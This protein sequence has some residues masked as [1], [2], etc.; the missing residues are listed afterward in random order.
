[1]QTEN[2]K[3][4]IGF[5]PYSVAGMAYIPYFLKSIEE[6]TYKDFTILAV[7]GNED[8]TD[9]NIKALAGYPQIKIISKG[10]NH[11]FGKSFNLMIN[12]SKKNGAEYFLVLNMDTILDKD[13]IK[14]MLTALKSNS[15]LGSVSPKIYKWNFA[16]EKLSEKTKIID[17]FGIILK[18]GL[19]FFDLGQ[20]QIDQGQFD[21][22]KI[23]GPSGAAAMY[24]MDALEKVKIDNQYFDEQMFMYK[25]DCDLAYRLFLAGYSSM[26]VTNAKIYHDRTAAGAGDGIFSVLSNRKNKSKQIKKWSLFHQLIII[27]KYWNLQNTL[28]KINIVWYVLQLFIFSLIF[29]QYLLFGFI[30][31]LKTKVKR[32]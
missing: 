32:Y 8:G 10:I 26:L 30:K 21:N 14:N 18:S 15:K 1:M 29:E 23:F 25:E 4:Y 28:N 11:G 27:K 13:C 24:R 16:P 12:E 31:I 5:I 7:D 3:L 2:K 6:Q 22:A 20:G 9:R 19:R 17:S